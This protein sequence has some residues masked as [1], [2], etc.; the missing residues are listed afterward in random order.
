VEPVRNGRRNKR[1]Q[2]RDLR[3]DTDLELVID[4]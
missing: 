2:S 3:G 1:A 4:K